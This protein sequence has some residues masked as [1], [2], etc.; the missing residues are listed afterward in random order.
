MRLQSLTHPESRSFLFCLNKTSVKSRLPPASNS[1][2]A[3]ILL[4]VRSQSLDNGSWIHLVPIWFPLSSLSLLP[5]LTQPASHTALLAGP[6]T[7]RAVLSAPGLWPIALPG[8]P[9][10]QAPPGRTPH[11]QVRSH[12]SSFS[13]RP[14]LSAFLRSPAGPHPFPA[15]AFSFLSTAQSLSGRHTW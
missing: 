2:V 5:H 3:P 14:T 4:R 9:V 11:C 6:H 1:A 7:P 10:P 12:P 8:T 13:V 15:S